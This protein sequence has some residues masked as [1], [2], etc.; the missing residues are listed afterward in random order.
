MNG[1]TVPKPNFA[2]SGVDV[3]IDE[4]WVKIQRKHEGR[5][6]ISVQH[7]AVGTPNSVHQHPVANRSTVD[8]KV[9]IIGACT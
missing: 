9:L 4:R 1:L 5:L 3:D 7:I 2:F 6:S 8:I